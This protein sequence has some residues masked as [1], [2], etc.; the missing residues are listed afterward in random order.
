LVWVEHD[1]VDLGPAPAAVVKHTLK[2]C[3]NSRTLNATLRHHGSSCKMCP[4]WGRGRHHTNKQASTKSA[5]SASPQRPSAFTQPR[6]INTPYVFHQ[7]N[8]AQCVLIGVVDAPAGSTHA[9]GGGGGQRALVAIALTASASPQTRCYTM[10]AMPVTCGHPGPSSQAAPSLRPAQACQTLASQ[11]QGLPL[12][13]LAVLSQGCLPS[14]SPQHHVFNQHV[15][16]VAGGFLRFGE[17]LFHRV[18]QRLLGRGAGQ[19]AG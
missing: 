9:P 19:Q 2:K 18:D 11:V 17:Q 4:V 13:S 16:A 3:Q 12:G 15:V 14:S 6:P 1:E 8:Q 5:C 7:L 10:A